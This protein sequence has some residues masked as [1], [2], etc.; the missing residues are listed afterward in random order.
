MFCGFF[1]LA[2]GV[3]KLCLTADACRSVGAQSG[4]NGYASRIDKDESA[5][6]GVVDMY[7]LPSDRSLFSEVWRF[8]RLIFVWVLVSLERVTDASWAFDRILLASCSS[9][10]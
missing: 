6:D 5:I 8:C 7:V 9:V 1:A 10:S 2:A 4:R 3:W